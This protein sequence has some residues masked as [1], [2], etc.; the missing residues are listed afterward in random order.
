MDV[1]RC[2]RSGLSYTYVITMNWGAVELYIDRGKYSEEANR[3]IFEKL[4]V[5]KEE[6][7]SDFGESLEWDRI[8]GRHSCR[9]RSTP[10]EAGLKDED[11]WGYLQDR[12][13]DAMIRLEKALKAH[14]ARLNV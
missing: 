3:K 9:I 7:E 1:S 6:I 14:I 8:K 12:M 2:G 13:I 5:K 11:K 10:S 4:S